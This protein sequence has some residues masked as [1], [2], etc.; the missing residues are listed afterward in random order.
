[1]RGAVSDRSI[2]ALDATERLR[3]FRFPASVREWYS[4]KGAVDILRRYSRADDLV[5]LEELGRVRGHLPDPVGNGLLAFRIENQ[6]VCV[7]AV[8]LDRSDDPPV[9]V[10]VDRLGVWQPCAQSFSQFVYCCVWDCGEEPKGIEAVQAQAQP[11][12]EQDLCWLHTHFVEG[13]R[14]Y[15][16]PGDTQYRFSRKDQKALIWAGDSQADWM[17]SA[18]S[19]ESLEELLRTVWRCGDLSHSLC[20]QTPAAQAVLERIRG[21]A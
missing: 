12:A 4:L 7:W 1:M 16:F 14:T 3:G 5:P 11:I 20:A 8:K 10:D 21:Y 6:G 19:A 2:A 13:P 15:G 17:L 9:M 18:G